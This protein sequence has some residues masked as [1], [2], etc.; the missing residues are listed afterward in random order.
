VATGHL[1]TGGLVLGTVAR[2]TE[3]GLELNRLRPDPRL[4]VTVVG[5]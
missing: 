3:G 2:L 1:G 5:P 4:P